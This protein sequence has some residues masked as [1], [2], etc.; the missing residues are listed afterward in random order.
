MHRT[1][2][3]WSAQRLFGPTGSRL[4]RSLDATSAHGWTRP[5]YELKLDH[6]AAVIAYVAGREPPAI[7]ALAEVESA[8]VFSDLLKRLP[9]RGL[10]IAIDPEA[11][12]AGDDLVVAYDSGAL[13]LVGDPTSHLVHNRFA[14][15]DIFELG[16]R[17]KKGSEFVLF[18]NH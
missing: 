16:F 18:T 17:T 15:R 3:W 5:A 2:I 12:L 14:T 8:A 11:Q 4:S 13:S 9:W 1:V 7:L 10:K 6:L